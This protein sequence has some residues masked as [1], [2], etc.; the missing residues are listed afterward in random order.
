MQA[1]PKLSMAPPKPKISLMNNKNKKDHI[2]QLM[3]GIE[4][5]KSQL[6]QDEP[7]P[8]SSAVS[9][10]R[11]NYVFEEEAKEMVTDCD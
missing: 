4:K 1:R 7:K 3:C 5:P 11:Q 8:P 9:A 10:Y 6:T 2:R